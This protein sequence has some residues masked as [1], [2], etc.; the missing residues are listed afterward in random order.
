MKLMRSPP[1]YAS[2]SHQVLKRTKDEPIQ[3]NPSSQL[4]RPA[5]DD[6]DCTHGGQK[7]PLASVSR[8]KWLT[9]PAE[10]PLLS[11]PV[12]IHLRNIDA[13]A[14]QDVLTQQ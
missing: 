6:G 8:F 14:M 9:L 11:A 7:T 5:Y 12:A 2:R 4:A 1:F 13:I 3:R 10:H